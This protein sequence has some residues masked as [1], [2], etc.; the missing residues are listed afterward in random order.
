[1]SDE[2]IIVAGRYLRPRMEL[3]VNLPQILAVDM[4]VDLRRRDVRVA[5][6]LLHGAKVG[7]ALQKMRRERM[8]QG[9]RR[10]VLLYAGRF[11]VPAEDLPGTHAAERT[12]GGIQEQH[13]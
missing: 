7:A 9:V 5:E 1:M 13:A 10:D 6:H 2:R 3:L 8:P 11:H 12:S 4:R